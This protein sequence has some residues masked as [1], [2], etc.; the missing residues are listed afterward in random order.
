MATLGRRGSLKFTKLAWD[1]EEQI[2]QNGVYV[3][4]SYLELHRQILDT[5]KHLDRVCRVNI[6]NY[7]SGRP[8]NFY[9]SSVDSSCSEL[10]GKEQS[11]LYC[12]FRDD[13]F[14]LYDGKTES[15]RLVKD[16]I[17]CDIRKC[18]E[19]L[20][21]RECKSFDTSIVDYENTA[22]IE[23]GIPVWESS[24]IP[25]KFAM[26]IGIGDST[27]YM[28]IDLDESLKKMQHDNCAEK[29]QKTRLSALKRVLNNI[30]KGKGGTYLT[31]SDTIH[32]TGRC[33][34]SG[35]YIVT[36]AVLR[37]LVRLQNNT[38]T[39]ISN[40]KYNG[41]PT[42]VRYTINTIISEIYLNP[43]R[44]LRYWKYR[45]VWVCVAP[46]VFQLMTQD[47][48]TAMRS[49]WETMMVGPPRTVRGKIIKYIRSLYRIETLIM[50]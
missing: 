48:I 28:N 22:W 10:I 12:R 40:K 41:I 32:K 42:N 9:I 44:L 3:Y 15:S 7:R 6:A 17:V 23:L 27:E 5:H 49:V 1:T 29:L 33:D 45:T 2:S 18:I 21:L 46:L 35:A 47:Q 25:V 31:I 37:A 43:D 24:I 19:P 39:P 36:M 26:E 20:E 38:F 11:V 8:D 16:K 34:V 14:I 30:R 4:N 13:F 50:L